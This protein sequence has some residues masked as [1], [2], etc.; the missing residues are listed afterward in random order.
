MML[1]LVMSVSSSERVAFLCNGGAFSSR[2][3][4]GSLGDFHLAPIIPIRMG[5]TG[6]D[7]RDSSS[8]PPSKVCVC[9]ARKNNISSITH[10]QMFVE[11]GPC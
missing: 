10:I 8:T 7:S 6:I 5:G 2:S 1:T 9:V 3:Q 11:T 4:C